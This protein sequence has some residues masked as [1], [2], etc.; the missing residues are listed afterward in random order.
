M[1]AEIRRNILLLLRLIVAGVFLYAGWQKFWVPQEFADSIA[2]YQIL[3]AQL[4]NPV[5]LAL[6]PLELIIGCLLLIGCQKR[7]AAF[8][9]LI[10]TGAFMVALT[11]AIARGLKIECGC[12]GAGGPVKG[13]LWPAVL[14]DIVLGTALVFLYFCEIG[15]T[16]K[17]RGMSLAHEAVQPD[18]GEAE[19]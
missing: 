7:I 14:R 12:F 5:A 1:K 19:T 11:S 17:G 4:I 6:P 9:A 10:L 16:G 3:P 18:S 15:T 13:D 8:S 2:A